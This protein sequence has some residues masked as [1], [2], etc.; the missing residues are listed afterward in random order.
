VQEDYRRYMNGQYEDH[1]GGA[2]PTY[3][4]LRTVSSA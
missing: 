4:R 2:G 1:A 3:R